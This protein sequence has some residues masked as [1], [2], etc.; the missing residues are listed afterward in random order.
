MATHIYI[1]ICLEQNSTTDS[2]KKKK[3]N[4][5]VKPDSKSST[6][7]EDWFAFRDDRREIMAEQEDCSLENSRETSVCIP[8]LKQSE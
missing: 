2:K 6:Q 4:F 5:L 8:V 7:S 3:Q 1:Y